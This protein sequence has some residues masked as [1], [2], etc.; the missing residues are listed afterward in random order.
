MSER[1]ESTYPE[2]TAGPTS[3][4]FG[5]ASFST[6]TTTALTSLWPPSTRRNSRSGSS[7]GSENQE[8]ESGTYQDDQSVAETEE[9][10]IR[11]VADEVSNLDDNYE[12]EEEEEEE[13]SEVS[14]GRNSQ[15]S[16]D[17]T[18]SASY[19]IQTTS[20]EYTTTTP[21]R[22]SLRSYDE[23][24]TPVYS[25]PYLTSSSEQLAGTLS[26]TTLTP[27]YTGTPIT[28]SRSYTT[29]SLSGRPTYS[30]ASP[31]KRTAGELIAFYE[32]QAHSRAASA[33][34]ET[35]FS[36]PGSPTKP[37]SQ[38]YSVPVGM[39]GALAAPRH[40]HDARSWRSG[41]SGK[42]L[43]SWS[44]ESDRSRSPVKSTSDTGSAPSG[45]VISG[46]SGYTRSGSTRSGYA[47]GLMSAIG[48]LVDSRAR[49]PRVLGL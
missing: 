47:G 8:S 7:C 6:F 41:G 37:G 40:T 18:L 13:N 24:S 43:S 28:H 34:M 21:T 35:G 19:H 44:F 45:S 48:G 39:P 4:I 42:T 31:Q 38:S 17:D 32:Q 1:S 46:T 27:T 36:R 11:L 23:S 2:S 14:A 9:G 30:Q 3:P 22:S 15:F 25:N 29:S 20:G 10:G 16:T 26:R 49:V 12:D 33:P 5:T